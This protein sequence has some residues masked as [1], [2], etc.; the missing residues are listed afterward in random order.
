MNQNIES[1]KRI[2]EALLFA[3]PEPLSLQT[4]QDYVPECENLQ[5]VLERLQDD[6]KDRGVILKSTQDRSHSYWAF[7]TSE[8]L[9][10]ALSLTQDVQK[11]PS[12]AAMETLAI[13]AYHQPITKAEIET[14]RGVAT[15]KGTFDTLIEAGWIKPG[16]RRETPG[17]PLTWVTTN[18][19]LDHFNLSSVKDLPGVEELRSSGLLDPRP[20][21]DI[22]S[23]IDDLFDETH[24]QEDENADLDETETT[25]NDHTSDDDN[26]QQKR[27][28]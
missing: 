21:L 26:I 14:V 25:D 13:V 18:D 22:T 16:R 19:F 8:D 28:S 27:A 3:S 23:E 10:D 5:Q 17:R 1:Y 11:Q 24:D 12:R 4:L 9:S 2:I 7:R 15:G 20:A 6:Y